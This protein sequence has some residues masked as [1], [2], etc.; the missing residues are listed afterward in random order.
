[1]IGQFTSKK[2]TKLPIQEQSHRESVKNPVKMRV[3][4]K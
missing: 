1:M 2:K 3:R 4:A